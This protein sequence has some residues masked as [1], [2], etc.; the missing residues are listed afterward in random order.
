[1][2]PPSRLAIPVAACLALMIGLVGLAG[3]FMDPI[4]SETTGH[5]ILFLLLVCAIGCGLV[6]ALVPEDWYLALIAAWGPVFISL[7][8]LVIK[9][10]KGGRS[11]YPYWTFLLG[12]LVAVPAATLVFGYCGSWM[13]RRF[14]KP[15]AAAR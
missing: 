1:M 11:P 10:V 5:R 3:V 13:R 12:T 9:L 8:A 15:S 14:S 6:G 7:P 4:P 2:T